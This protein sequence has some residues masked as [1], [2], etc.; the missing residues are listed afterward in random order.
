MISFFRVIL[1]IYFYYLETA[2]CDFYI[3]EVGNPKKWIYRCIPYNS[4]SWVKTH[5]RLYDR[6]ISRNSDKLNHFIDPY[7][8]AD[9]IFMIHMIANNV[10]NHVASDLFFELWRKH[11]SRYEQIINNDTCEES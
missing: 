7:L 9:G 1:F 10:G 11:N 3:R 6:S 2:L 8:E 5:V 4:S